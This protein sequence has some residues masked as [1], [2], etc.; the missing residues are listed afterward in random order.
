[1]RTDHN[2]NSEEGHI[3]YERATLDELP[4]WS[5]SLRLGVPQET[6]GGQK[7]HSLGKDSETTA[8]Y[9][10]EW[11]PAEHGGIGETEAGPCVALDTLGT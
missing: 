11:A 1:M 7:R 4:W 8:P 2:E 6:V 10:G 3:V 9:T 5:D